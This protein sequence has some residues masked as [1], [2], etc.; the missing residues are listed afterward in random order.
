MVFRLEVYIC[1]LFWVY[2]DHEERDTSSTINGNQLKL[3][4]AV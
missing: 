3:D 4:W 2:V 1:D